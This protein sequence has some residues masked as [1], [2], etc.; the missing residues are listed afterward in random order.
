MFLNTE[1]MPTTGSILIRIGVDDRGKAYI[2]GKLLT[3]NLKVYYPQKFNISRSSRSISVHVTNKIFVI[4]L[5]VVIPGVPD[6]TWK[7]TKE[8]QKGLAWTTAG[9]ND[10]S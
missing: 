1:S 8:D 9:F 5:L 4:G 10:S 2:D 6:R 3:D 7:C